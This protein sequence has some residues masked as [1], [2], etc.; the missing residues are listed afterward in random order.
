MFG[1]VR[2]PICG[3]KSARTKPFFQNVRLVR[4]AKMHSSRLPRGVENNASMMVRP[5]NE[6]LFA[7][8]LG[9]HDSVTVQ[10]FS[11]R[12]PDD[13]PQLSVTP[14]WYEWN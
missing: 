2:L 5:V 4:A 7:L 14:M 11:Y 12:F 9:F 10:L 1:I 6:G 13:V 3:R 8:V